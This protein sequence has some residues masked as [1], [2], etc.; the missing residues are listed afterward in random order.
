MRPKVGVGVL[1]IDKGRILLGERLGSHGEG[2]W[3]PPGGHLEFGESP[4]ECAA[5]ELQEEA[6]L[7][8]TEIVVQHWS[9]DIF[10]EEKKH[11]I[12]LFAIVKGFEGRVELREPEKCRG[13]HWFPVG[14][15]PQPLFLPLS[16][17]TKTHGL[18]SLLQQPLAVENM[19]S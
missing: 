5:R 18:S 19:G 16:N 15:L 3:S 12:T 6:G 4:E 13:W 8:A 11:Y 9:N 10:H 17:F 1:V 7:V 14:E 2:T